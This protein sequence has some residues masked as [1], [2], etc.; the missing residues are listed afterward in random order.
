MVWFILIPFTIKEIL[1]KK[2]YIKENFF[3]IGLIEYYQLAPLT[4][5]F[6]LL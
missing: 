6:I 1:A 2:N 4:Q 3:V 5:L